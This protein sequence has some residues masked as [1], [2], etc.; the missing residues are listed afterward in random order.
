MN[1]LA[2]EV[3]TMASCHE[4]KQGEVYI[5][6]ECG[7]ELKV[8]AQCK[9][10]GTSKEAHDHDTCNFICCEAEMSVKN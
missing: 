9:N 1:I 3:Q 6:K 7:L 8:V 10:H 4:M 2:K 5:C